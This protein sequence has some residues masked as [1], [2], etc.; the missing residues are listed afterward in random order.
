[1]AIQ[2]IILAAGQGTR[3]LTE[4]PKVL[5]KIA[6]KPMLHHIL[7]TCA[8]LNASKPIVI[9]GYQAEVLK[10]ATEPFFEVIWQHQAQQLGTAHAVGLGLEH[11]GNDDV[12]VV[13]A[14]DVP[15]ISVQTLQALIAQCSEKH[16]ALVTQVLD[17]PTGYGRIKHNQHGKVVGIV[18]HKDAS[19][20]ELEIREINTGIM[21]I[22]AS[23]LK[24]ALPEI[25]NHNAQ[26]EYYLTDLIELAAK[27][28]VEVNT[29]QAA[30]DYEVK[31]VN[32]REQLAELEREYQLHLAH[33]F[34]KA[35]GVSFADPARVDFRGSS[36]FEKDVEVDVNVIFEGNNHIGQACHIGANCVLKN[37]V[38]EA[39]VQ[40]EAMSHLEGVH[41]KK[42]AVI[43]PFARLRPGSE[44]GEQAR[45]GNF[46]EVKK[47]V[48][49]KGSKANHLSYIGDAEI[50]D[51][52]NIGAGTITCNYDGVNK[53]QTRI[54]EG[55][56]IGSNT[57][58]VAPVTIGKNS[59]IGAGSTI[60]KNTPANKLTL[61][62]AKQ[63]VIENWTRPQKNKKTHDA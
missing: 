50:G 45:V 35:Q 2:F 38:L 23:F 58:L 43:G 15:F 46:V 13:L 16:M 33:F 27:H 28:G 6:G 18:E 26:K 4:Q 57:S 44:I 59:N 8:A 42:N 7:E 30:H 39:G 32:S 5:A 1:M 11:V 19:A 9:C 37:V 14:G 48:L 55:A 53:Y 3:M 60:T 31:G 62:R 17:D 12:V 34:M 10:A 24:K 21:A 63:L 22:P 61:A 56:F 36:V 41:V 20:D 40:I 51:S 47:S 29:L 25:G 52:V 49:G 54:E